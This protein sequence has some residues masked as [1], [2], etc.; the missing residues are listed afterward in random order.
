[1]LVS[2][3]R[4]PHRAGA[5][6]NEPI[7]LSVTFLAGAERDYGRSGNDTLAAFE[8]ALGAV[9]G[10]RAIAFSSGMAAAAAVIEGLPT[11]STVVLPSSYYNYHRNLLNAGVELGRLT[12]RTVDICDTAATTAALDGATLLWLELPTNPMLRVADLP[13]LTAAA[14]DRG[15]LT[16]VDATVATPVGM[17]ALTHGADIAMHSVTKWLAGHSDL[18]MGALVT[19]DTA[20]AE[21]LHDRRT[22][23][24]AVPG[25][26]ESYLALRGLRTLAVRFERASSNATELAARLA[27][28]PAVRAVHHPSRPDHPDADRIARLLSLPGGLLSFRPTSVELAEQVCRRVRLI[29]HATSLG[30]VESLIERRGAYPGEL[31]QA[32]PPELLRLSVGIEHVE[33]LWADLAQALS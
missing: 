18:L 24:G 23:T 3:G 7:A 28:H 11:G 33:D 19:A 8:E 31:A 16:V 30:G 15:V 12:M 13:A 9:E 32:T 10:G 22:L 4:P 5:P 25:V 21:R 26:L 6:V 1:V 2:A 14:R 29:T 27:D 17:R 20:L